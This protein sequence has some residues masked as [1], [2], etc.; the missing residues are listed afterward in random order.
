MT[1]FCRGR[2]EGTAELNDMAKVT[3]ENTGLASSVGFLGH[4]VLVPGPGD[5][6]CGGEC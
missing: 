6:H 5:D 1:P 3:N 2:K 4:C